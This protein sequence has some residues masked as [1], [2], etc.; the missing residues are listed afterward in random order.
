[1]IELEN[2]YFAIPKEITDSA[3]LTGYKWMEPSDERMMK[4]FYKG[5]YY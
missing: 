2:H 3:I 4:N 5:S 1:M